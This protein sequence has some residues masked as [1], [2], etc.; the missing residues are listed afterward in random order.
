MKFVDV[1]IIVLILI[2]L[3]VCIRVASKPGSSCSGC[4]VIARARSDALKIK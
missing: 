2:L 4:A 3:G 1:I